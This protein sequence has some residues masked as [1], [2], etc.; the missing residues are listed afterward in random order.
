MIIW[1]G[2]NNDLPFV[3][4]DLALCVVDPLRPGDELGTYPGE[5]NLRMADV[6]VVNKVDQATP[7]QL[8]VVRRS[9]AAVAPTGGRG[10]GPLTGDAGART[11]PGGCPRPGHR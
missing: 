1:D 3:R 4:P 9:I 5:V 11:G 2:G 7:E 8:D 6:A 10:H